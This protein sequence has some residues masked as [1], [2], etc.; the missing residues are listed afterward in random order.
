MVDTLA[1]DSFGFDQLAYITERLQENLNIDPANIFYQLY[2]FEE[3]DYWE[4]DEQG[5]CICMFL[6]YADK[7]N[8]IEPVTIEQNIPKKTP[9]PS[10]IAGNSI[11]EYLKRQQHNKKS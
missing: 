3:F 9:N 1:D 6:V 4:K 10:Q 7:E 8:D 2:W 5:C 11:R